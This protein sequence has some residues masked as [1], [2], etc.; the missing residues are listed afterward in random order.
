MYHHVGADCV[1]FPTTDHAVLTLARLQHQLQHHLFV[2]PDAATVECMVD[3]SKFYHSLHATD[4][5]HPETWYPADASCPDLARKVSY[6]VYVRPAQS[7]QFLQYFREKGFTAH[8]PRELRYYLEL[9]QQHQVPVMVQQIV[10]GPTDDGYNIKGYF[11]RGGML[12][13]LISK[14]KVWQPTM[15]SNP[16]VTVTI[17][18]AD[19][20]KFTQPFLKYMKHHNYR[21]LF[22]A[23]FKRDS[24]DGQVKLLEVNARSMGCSYLGRACGADDIYAAYR[25]ALGK[26][27]VTETYQPGLHWISEFTSL[28]TI[29]NHLRHRKYR[30]FR[31]IGTILAKRHLKYLS[32]DDPVPS[33]VEAIHRVKQF[34]N[35]IRE[36]DNVIKK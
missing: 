1:L 8:S 15:F 12:A 16:S 10:E 31:D 19:A 30:W 26:D 34:V 21:G 18:H 2:L 3:K 6:P 28:W 29:I 25:D 22:G 17:P 13:L 33:A 20:E 9:A 35:W 4:I 23:E 7:L 5:Q 11:N 32:G 36:P 24:R 14:R 27:I